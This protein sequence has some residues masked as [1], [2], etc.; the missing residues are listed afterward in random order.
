M[1]IDHY[2]VRESRK[3]T[4]TIHIDA[5]EMGRII[6]NITLNLYCG[7]LQKVKEVEHL[8]TALLE[9]EIAYRGSVEDVGQS[10]SIPS[11]S[12]NISGPSMDIL[13]SSMSDPGPSMS[14]PGPSTSWDVI[15][16]PHTCMDNTDPS[17]S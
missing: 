2:L 3:T 9:D 8:E 5:S 10:I 15:G 6:P 12:K 11:P 7:C 13:S 14:D 17:L 4:M 1:Y 16:P